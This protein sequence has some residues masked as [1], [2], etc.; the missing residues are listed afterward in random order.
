LTLAER[1]Y[2]LHSMHQQRSTRSVH[3]ICTT[4]TQT[5]YRKHEVWNLR[6]IIS[7]AAWTRTKAEFDELLPAQEE[8]ERSGDFRNLSCIRTQ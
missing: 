2:F 8:M 5:V 7:K 6:E 1:D 4:E 3:G